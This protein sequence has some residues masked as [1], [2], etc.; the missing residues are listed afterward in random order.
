MIKKEQILESSLSLAETMPWDAVT[1]EEIAKESNIS[2]EELQA[3]FEDKMAIIAYWHHILDQSIQGQQETSGTDT[4]STNDILFDVLMD[5]FEALNSK[6]QASLSIIESF[7]K[8]PKDGLFCIPYLGRSMAR[9]L[10]AADISSSG[11]KGSTAL[12]GLCVIYVRVLYV[13]MH[14]DSA[15]MGK[16]M[17][18]LDKTLKQAG[19]FAGYLGLKND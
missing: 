17:A 16:T 10:D 7:K 14:D 8:E 15:D 4:L 3:L 13:W 11:Y 9:V 5:R 2:I 6:R 19:R 1:F 18:T 12:L